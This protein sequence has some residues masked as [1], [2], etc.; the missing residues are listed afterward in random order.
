MNTGRFLSGCLVAVS[1]AASPAGA[2]TVVSN[3]DELVAAIEDEAENIEVEG[4]IELGR[5]QSTDNALP[6]IGD[7]DNTQGFSEFAV[8]QGRDGAELRAAGSGF[9]LAE[10][11]DSGSL[12]L[13]DIKISGFDSPGPGGALMVVDGRLHLERVVVEDN[14]SDRNGGA[15]L[16]RGRDLTGRGPDVELRVT[17]SR[18]SGNTSALRGGAVH[19]Y[20]AIS[21]VEFKRNRFVDNDASF[22]CAVSLQ[23]SEDVSFNG[24]VFRG[25]CDQ[26]LVDATRGHQGFDFYR[27]TWVASSGPAYRF[28]LR[29]DDEPGRTRMGGNLL[30]GLGDDPV[31]QADVSGNPDNAR[32]H[33][34]GINVATDDSC[35][36]DRDTDRVV[37]D[38]AGLV[39]GTG[40][41]VP[42]EGGIALDADMLRT[43]D[44]NA[45]EARCG[46]ADARGL[47]RPQ[48]GND[49]GVAECDRGAIE[50]RNGSD[51]GPAHSGAYFDPARP[52]EGYFVDI[53]EDGRAW[54]T[55]FTYQAIGGSPAITVKEPTWFFGL[56][57]VVGNSVVVPD[58]NELS[59]IEFA[60]PVPGITRE[61][62]ALSLVF[63]DCDS[64]RDNPGTAYF[65]SKQLGIADVP[66]LSDLFTDAVRLSSVVPCGEAQPHPKAGLSGN[67]FD[68]ERNGEGIQVQWMPD[69]RVLV[70]WYTFAPEGGPI[71]M[72]SDG[73]TVEGNT[74]TAPM[75]YPAEPTAFG[76]DFDASEIG[77]EPWG[78]LT[79]EYTGCD[80]IELG[81]ESEIEGFGSGS[82]TY[83]RLTR[84]AGTTC[85]L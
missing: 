37:D 25:D 28:R 14:H 20:Q 63:K 7:A 1:F 27:N 22:G 70:V 62:G 19:L 15:V 8:I 54:V 48:D 59:G 57:R 42:L 18:F 66:V 45:T 39:A 44:K 43:T 84:L 12:V 23:R 33:S 50:K 35:E 71:W 6:A 3:A 55:M 51:V 13:R 83:Q 80:T 31:C 61:S 67:F 52:G 64:G 16:A 32:I 26:A 47:G 49:D 73:A 76:P 41:P 78:T 29:E 21:P 2:Q 75:I 11:L 10:V 81:F 68:P 60:T 4:V 65:R 69:G 74:V 46:I 36:L 40:V 85:D 5:Y 9:R 38:A 17:D 82:F 56:G 72:I 34:F 79:L 58:L 24:N 53:L 30:V 77:L